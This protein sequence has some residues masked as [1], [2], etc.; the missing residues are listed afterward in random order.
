MG[1]SGASGLVE[2]ELGDR[3]A[4]TGAYGWG[5]APGRKFDRY[6]ANAVIDGSFKRRNVEMQ[7]YA[8]SYLMY[9]CIKRCSLRLYDI[10]M[11]K[12]IGHIHDVDMHFVSAYH[13]FSLWQSG[14][15][16]KSAENPFWCKTSW[17]RPGHFMQDLGRRSASSVAEPRSFG[18]GPYPKYRR[19]HLHS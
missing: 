18:L 8:I 17:R 2:V 19:Q 1:N 14:S 11:R 5:R 6:A 9:M 13:Q 4:A 12:Y 3:S 16:H 15:T 7:N 10:C